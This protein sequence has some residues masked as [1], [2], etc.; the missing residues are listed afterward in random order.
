MH[1][2][3]DSGDRFLVRANSPCS[4]HEKSQFTLELATCLFARTR[5][6]AT[7]LLGFGA[8]LA[9]LELGIA[10]ADHIDTTTSLNDLAIRMAIFQGANTTN[11]FHRIDLVRCF[12]YGFLRREKYSEFA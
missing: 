3:K 11:D 4:R 12:G 1:E 7:G 8:A 9:D 6:L 10:F 2:Q 5:R